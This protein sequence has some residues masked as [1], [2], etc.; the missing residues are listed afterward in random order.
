MHF[1]ALPAHILLP[2][3]PINYYSP[4]ANTKAKFKHY[5]QAQT[6][7]QPTEMPPQPLLS[8]A[9]TSLCLICFTHFY[10]A[11][12]FTLHNK[13]TGHGRSMNSQA[14]HSFSSS[15]LSGDEDEGEGIVKVS[16]VRLSHFANM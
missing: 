8:S 14:G 5:L 3:L 2:L 15:S 11:E 9:T 1:L 6:T 10:T 13:I 7:T 16:R 4:T 12:D